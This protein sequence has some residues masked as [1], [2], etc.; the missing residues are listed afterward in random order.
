[1]SST[2]MT[3]DN[4]L[5]VKKWAME[6]WLNVGPK[7]VFGH[8]F[9]RGA[10]YFED[11]FIGARAKGDQMTYDYTGK[12]TGVPIGEGGTLDGNEEA[13][14]LGSFT[15]AMNTTRLGVLNPND[16]TIEQQRTNVK[17]ENKARTVIPNRH[18]ELINIGIFQQ[19]A[20]A[21]PTS[22]TM[23]GVTWSGDN[24]K[25]VRGHNPI[26]APTS[27]RIIRAGGV[28]NDQSLTSSDI[29]SLD[30]I[31]YAL[32]KNDT[33]EQPIERFDDGTFDLYVSPEQLVDLQHNS[34][35]KIQWFN[36]Q[37]AK[38]TGGKDNELEK[39]LGK[40]KMVV[41]G[42]Y[43]DVFIYS[44]LHVA[45]G[46]NSGNSSVITTTRRAVLTG[47]DALAFASPFGGR[48]SDNDV[49]FRFKTQ[50]KDYDYYKGIEGRF[51]GGFKKNTPSNGQDIGT[52]V[53]STYGAS[54]S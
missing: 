11:E 19:L 9:D 8:M 44:N 38:I 15:L 24:R 45:Y 31:D 6:G 16:D 12:L 50:L 37:L 17:F 7:T 4:A 49:P 34:A 27:D 18:A 14:D 42:R 46:V 41:A 48:P 21:D 40:G 3:T 51:I 47:K 33:S 13:L 52:L 30:L 1:M 5:T 39:G 25:F 20:G 53:I 2:Q 29:M 23:G 10:V 54:H 43:R 26:V 36:I 22:W 35:S 32:E 28:S